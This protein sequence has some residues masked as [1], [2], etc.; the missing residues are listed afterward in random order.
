M[1]CLQKIKLGVVIM[2]DIKKEI[3]QI[4]DKYKLYCLSIHSNNI[5]P[6]KETYEFNL[7]DLEIINDY[8]YVKLTNDDLYKRINYI[9]Y[10]RL[11]YNVLSIIDKKIIYYTYLDEDYNYDDRYIA[12]C[13]G[14]SVGYYY[15]KKKETLMRFAY[16]LGI[17]K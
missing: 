7:E 9:N 3:K 14:W 10:V 12:N 11:S 1:L 6:N 17:K 4:L 16:S 2:N 5:I 15:V 8:N 13:L